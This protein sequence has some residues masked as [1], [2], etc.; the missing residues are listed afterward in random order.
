MA[1]TLEALHAVACKD[2]TGMRQKLKMVYT[3]IRF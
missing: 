3:G 2:A 1:K